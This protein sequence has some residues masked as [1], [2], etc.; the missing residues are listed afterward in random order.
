MAAHFCRTFGECRC[1]KFAGFFD[2]WRCERAESP[3]SGGTDNW[4]TQTRAEQ[5]KLSLGSNL[6]GKMFTEMIR[7]QAFAV[8]YF[9]DKLVESD[10]KNYGP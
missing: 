8:S 10:A 9:C 6:S 7:V 5:R 4:R 2:I 3:N 1:R